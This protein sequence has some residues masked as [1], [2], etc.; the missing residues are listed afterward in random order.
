MFRSVTELSVQDPNYSR[1][2]FLVVVWSFPS[3]LF[4]LL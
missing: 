2:V 3:Q 1:V 4:L